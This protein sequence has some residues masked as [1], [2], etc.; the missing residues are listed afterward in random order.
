MKKTI[1]TAMVAG[2]MGYVPCAFGLLI[3]AS[4]LQK[5]FTSEDAT[6]LNYMNGGFGVSASRGPWK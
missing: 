3:N 2:L 1:L 5:E 6:R 4:M